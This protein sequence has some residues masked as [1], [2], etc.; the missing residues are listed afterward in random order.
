M[1]RRRTIRSPYDLAVHD[2]PAQ[3]PLAVLLPRVGAAVA[4]HRR[5][6]AARHGLT[7]TA[8]DVLVALAADDAPSH[9]EVAAR[10][11]LSPATLTPVLDALEA[12]GRIHRERDPA[13]RRV[14]RVHR[15]AAGREHLAAATQPVAGLPEP[16]PDQEPVIR[17]YLLAVLAAVEAE[18]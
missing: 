9:R 3:V 6:L 13:D 12:A 7:P 8:I 4:R 5:R 17:A 15:T 10:L 16:G 18:E 1:I 14:V 11:G 2:D